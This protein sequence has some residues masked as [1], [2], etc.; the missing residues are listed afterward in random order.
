MDMPISYIKLS[1]FLHFE[2]YPLAFLIKV[3]VSAE[4][5]FELR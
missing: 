4:G 2:V 1:I 5:K 3:W